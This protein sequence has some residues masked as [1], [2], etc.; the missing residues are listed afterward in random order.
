V[1][2]DP[3]RNYGSRLLVLDVTHEPLHQIWRTLASLFGAEVQCTFEPVEQ[4][5]RRLV[6]HQTS[7]QAGQNV[8]VTHFGH[9]WALE[10]VWADLRVLVVP[11]IVELQEM[12]M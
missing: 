12:L 6:R 9:C 8:P 2:L 5:S 3:T 1:S 11:L 7:L 10:S 4:I